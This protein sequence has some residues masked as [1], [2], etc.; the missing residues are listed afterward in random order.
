MSINFR[1]NTSTKVSILSSN[2]RRYLQVCLPFAALSS[3]ILTKKFYVHVKQ[4]VACD[5]THTAQ[6]PR[7]PRRRSAAAP[8]LRLWFRISLGAWMFLC[9]ECCVLSGWGLCDELITRPEDS[10]RL[11][12]VVLCDLQTSW[13]RRPWPTGCCRAKK[14]TEN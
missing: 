9:C 1:I 4:S 8:L 2:Y 13:M 14:Q 3:F 7:G 12:C 11:W 5:V 6:C 10:D